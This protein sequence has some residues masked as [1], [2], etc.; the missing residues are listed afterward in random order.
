MNWFRFRFRKESDPFRKICITILLQRSRAEQV[1]KV[2]KALFARFPTIE[3]LAEANLMSIL[4]A[5]R[6]IGLAERKARRLKEVAKV[7]L[8]KYGGALPKTRER[9]LALPGVGEYTADILSHS[10]LGKPAVAVDT[11]VVR[12]LTRLDLIQDRREAKTFLEQNLPR[13]SWHEF[14]KILLEFGM[15]VCRPKPRCSKCPL[16]DLC[17]SKRRKSA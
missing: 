8:E 2:Y 5:L 3:A 16:A 13:E 9:F 14:N 1:D 10:I 6:P 15:S 7:I 12:I 4:E 17:S 11:N